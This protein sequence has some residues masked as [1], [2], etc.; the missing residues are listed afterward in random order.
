MDK[1]K[2]IPTQDNI[3]SALR[4]MSE[5][6]FSNGPQCVSQERQRI[7]QSV[8]REQLR[9]I[10]KEL[11][12]VISV[13]ITAYLLLK[14]PTVKHRIVELLSRPVPSWQVLLLCL[15]S[16]VPFFSLLWLATYK[17]KDPT[18]KRKAWRFAL[19]YALIIFAVLL[20]ARFA[21]VCAGSDCSY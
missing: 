2:Q 10:I 5:E 12:L 16:L 7:V 3:R 17:L 18:D 14:Q 9:K 21:R 19:L 11:A 6:A 15:P 20:M 8:R 13:V 1:P 4:Q